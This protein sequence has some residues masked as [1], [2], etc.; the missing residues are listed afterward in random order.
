MEKVENYS[1]RKVVNALEKGYLEVDV[2]AYGVVEKVGMYFAQGQH[3]DLHVNPVIVQS[4]SHIVNP[5]I[6]YA[7]GSDSYISGDNLYIERRTLRQVTPGDKIRVEYESV[8]AVNSMNLVV[9]V[10]VLYDVFS[11]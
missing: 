6:I 3:F 7:D 4:G 5:L 8:D 11:K 10:E 2:P 1:F 9:D